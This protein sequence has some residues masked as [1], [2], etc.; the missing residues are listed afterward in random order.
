MRTSSSISILRGNC[1]T[2][3]M[4]FIPRLRLW[5]SGLSGPPGPPVNFALLRAHARVYA[6][7]T[8][9]LSDPHAI[10]RPERPDLRDA[11]APGTGAALPDLALNLR[12]ATS[13]LP[14]VSQLCRDIGLNRQQVNK[15]LNGGSRPS[16]YNLRRI[17][18]YLGI[19]P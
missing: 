10:P 15:Y 17:A 13:F 1:S 4:L 18:G 7:A 19:D 5:G 6:R 12:F 3:R 8:T 14:S 11:S 9:M 16:P 2:V